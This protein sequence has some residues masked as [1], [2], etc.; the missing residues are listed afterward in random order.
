MSDEADKRAR[1]D[2]Q[3]N[4]LAE[5]E[6]TMMLQMLQDISRHLGLRTRSTI[7]LQGLAK[8]TKVEDLA[9][10]LEVALPSE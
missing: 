2:L 4:L 6:T 10:K 9:R 8:E 1:L 7:E 3:V 5:K